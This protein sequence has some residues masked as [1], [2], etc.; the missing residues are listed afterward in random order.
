M[1]TEKMA[2]PR[3]EKDICDQASMLLYDEEHVRWPVQH[4]TLLFSL[5]LTLRGI[6]RAIQYDEHEANRLL[7][8]I[9]RNAL[10]NAATL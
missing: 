1:A 2:E 4:L 6:N 5:A 10:S 3:S 8:F 9:V 7:S